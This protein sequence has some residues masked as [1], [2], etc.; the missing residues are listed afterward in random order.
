MA[1]S[2]A[3]GLVLALCGL[4]SAVLVQSKSTA[5]IKQE[6]R[7]TYDALGREKEANDELL[8]VVAQKQQDLYFQSIALAERE[9]GVNN[10][11][12]AEQLLDAC[13]VK[14][15][16]WE[17][18]YLKRLCRGRVPPLRHAA[19]V[20]F[21]AISPS[22]EVLASSDIE[23]GVTLWDGRSYQKLRHIRA[24]KRP[25]WSLAFSHDGRCL[26][27][28]S[29]DG[30]VKTWAVPTGKQLLEL[31]GDG[32]AVFSVSLSPDGR[33]ASLGIAELTL[34][35][36]ATGKRLSS[37][38]VEGGSGQ[39]VF[40][41]DGRRLASVN[42]RL[43]AKVW[44]AV[45]GEVIHSLPGP[46][47]ELICVAFSPDGRL[48]AAG[49]GS[50]RFRKNG[51]V[52]V[53][54]TETGGE[55]HTL[56]GHVEILASVAFSPDSRRLASAGYDQTIKIWDVQTGREALNLRGHNNVI[57][58]L[59][60]SADGRLFSG[61]DDRTIR[62]WDG[63]DW[64]EGEGG[65]ELLDLPGHDEGVTGVA[66][67]R[68]GGRFASADCRGI[69]NLR[70]VPFLGTNRF[71]GDRTL[72][73]SASAV[74]GVA[75][76]S[77]GELLAASGENTLNVWQAST[78]NVVLDLHGGE[79]GNLMCVAFSP[80]R[81]HLAAG[82]WRSDSAVPIWDLETGQK[83]H[84]LPGLKL[85]VNALAFSPSDGRYLVT[86]GEDGAVRV[87]DWA[88]ERELYELPP[89]QEGR[90]TGVAFSPDGQRLACCGWDRTIRIWDI[91]GPDP[92][93]WKPHRPLF[94][95]T[96]SVECVAFSPDGRLLAWGS[97]DSTVKIC[98]I[99]SGRAEGVSPS[100]HTLYG[101][102]NWVLSVAFSIDGRQI[103]SGSQDGTV[104]I[105]AVPSEELSHVL[106]P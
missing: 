79:D 92:R 26:A 71:S 75:F 74:Y 9:L 40:G 15:R 1:T 65:Q 91:S 86:A 5:R 10:V 21:V 32:R 102:T 24:H 63:R 96:G 82:G 72:K 43:V 100:I 66:F 81:R 55:L 80:D 36:V 29:E 53:W 77:D 19:A 84:Q 46:G 73:T 58:S 47:R 45:T 85:A 98:A 33:L 12:R 93:S 59:A 6:Q 13:A 104:K 2:L 17:W 70:K 30:T 50:H 54:E 88:A 7:Q 62:V 37:F 41:P 78:G 76:S 35:D 69:I 105:W 106:V 61:S 87:W 4:V 90:V 39:V 48:L 25:V 89:R 49:S 23:G 14:L 20:Y 51:E 56:S 34:W 38:Q 3:L 99:E 103:A 8:R 42:Q 97:T 11:S 57:G 68:Q 28:A 94:D 16:A 101:H 83:T 27:S 22:G 52:R 60:F 31:P 67:S 95:P 64:H 44:D 18:H